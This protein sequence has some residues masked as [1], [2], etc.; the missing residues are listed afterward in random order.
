[1]EEGVWGFQ[2]RRSVMVKGWEMNTLFLVFDHPG[3]NTL[4]FGP[5]SGESGER[6]ESEKRRG[7]HGD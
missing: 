4:G 6:W 1:V 3:H 5:P 7:T 2:F